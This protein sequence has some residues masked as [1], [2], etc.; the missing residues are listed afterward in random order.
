M[1]SFSEIALKG[2]KCTSENFY[3]GWPKE[4]RA[5]KIYATTFFVPHDFC[6]ITKITKYNDK[7]K[8]A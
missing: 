7:S 4:N 5:Q 6:L 3:D 8:A 1:K 2:Y